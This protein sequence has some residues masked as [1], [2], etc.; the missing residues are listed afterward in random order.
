MT[1]TDD[2]VYT[3]RLLGPTIL[4]AGT[5]SV[6][7]CPVYRA[8]ALVAPTSGTVDVYDET[9]TLIV[10]AAV[11]VVASIATYTVLATATA[12]KV[13]SEGWRFEWSLVLSPTRTKNF[14]TD[15]V[16][17]LHRL[18]PVIADVDLLQLHPELARLMPPTE[19]N[20]QD[21]IDAV[22]GEAESRL[23]GAGRRPWL[24]LSAHA[25][26]MYLL[27]GALSAVWRML[28]TGGEGTREWSLSVDYRTTAAG[29][30][31]KLALVY[32][33]PT[34]GEN[35]DAP[36]K[37]RAGAPVLWLSGRPRSG[38]IG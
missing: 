14:R 24:I 26:R 6:I 25:L 30:W 29:E 33:T 35:A 5:D 19:S 22:F 11:V 36:G 12:A 37:K 28:A 4:E 13:P 31:D 27:N 1:T 17:A 15:G 20:Y 10:S 16:L 34:T 7:T 38:W 9:N 32:A 21:V 23:V 18:Y 3:A 8:G 2:A